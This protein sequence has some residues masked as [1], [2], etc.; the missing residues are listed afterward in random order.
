M[1]FLK[2]H[3][4]KVILSVV[5][6]GLVVAAAGLPYLVAKTRQQIEETVSGV[7]KRQ[8]KPWKVTNL[9]TNQEA[10]NRMVAPVRLELS[11]GHNLFNPVRWLRTPSGAL[12]KLDTGGK[13]G[14]EAVK[15]L[16]TR[17]LNLNVTFDVAGPRGEGMAYNVAVIR[18][19]GVGSA[20]PR[21]ASAVP[22]QKAQFFR[23]TKVE[24]NPA[25]PSALHIQLDPKALQLDDDFPSI[26]V[27]KGQPY[28][29]VVGYLADL[30][31]PFDNKTF[32]GRKEGDSIALS[33]DRT[34]QES[35]KIVVITEDQVVLSAKSTK[36]TTI[37]K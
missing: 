30:E 20:S 10:L 6:L 18:E 15:I 9:T 13:I 37:R 25:D 2:K 35:Y 23:I 12:V 28:N 3:Y 1:D 36:K 22:L 11:G 29:Q 14:P 33:V 16:A 4:E 24:G 19:T 31:Y 32:L 8:P 34:G 26:V 27:Q 17:P 7:V 21:R 5:L